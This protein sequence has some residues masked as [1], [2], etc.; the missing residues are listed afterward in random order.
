[1]S[2]PLRS[3]AHRMNAIRL[4]ATFTTLATMYHTAAYSAVENVWEF[5]TELAIEVTRLSSVAR[6][7][8]TVKQ[9]FL[10]SSY[11]VDS[12]SSVVVSLGSRLVRWEVHSC[13]IQTLWTSYLNVAAANCQL[14]RKCAETKLWD[15]VTHKIPYNTNTMPYFH[16]SLST[17]IPRMSWSYYLI[18]GTV[19][20]TVS[21]SRLSVRFTIAANLFDSIY[22]RQSDDTRD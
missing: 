15:T 3:R 12:L 21:I 1:M 9:L 10:L 13:P 19:Y 17:A 6:L 7:L 16:S 11:F 8:H 20:L 18:I 5:R 14:Q 2:I 4:I 22:R